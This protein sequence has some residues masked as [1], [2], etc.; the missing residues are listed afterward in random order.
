MYINVFV[1]LWM[2]DLLLYL[3]LIFLSAR[4]CEESLMDVFHD[5]TLS[6]NTHM[7]VQ[8]AMI[9]KPF[10][11]VFWRWYI[12]SSIYK[13]VV[14]FYAFLLRILKKQRQGY[15]LAFGF[16]GQMWQ[17][18]VEV[19]YVAVNRAWSSNCDMGS[20]VVRTEI[21]KSLPWNLQTLNWFI[22]ILWACRPRLCLIVK[23]FPENQKDVEPS[24][25]WWGQGKQREGR[26]FFN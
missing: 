1:A 16:F 23:V 13:P 12:E 24:W 21:F 22:L 18:L 3:K 4:L 20:T 17:L 25:A 11:K 7:I 14:Q 10:H 26:C 8:T 2:P 5:K 15:L 9:Y 6:K 19:P